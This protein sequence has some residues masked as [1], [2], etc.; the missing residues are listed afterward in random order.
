MTGAGQRDPWPRSQLR[1]YTLAA[2]K[3]LKHWPV[4]SKA[5][6]SIETTAYTIRDWH[7]AEANLCELKGKMAGC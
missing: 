1:G 2:P 4:P 5:K 3:G 6:L 7:V